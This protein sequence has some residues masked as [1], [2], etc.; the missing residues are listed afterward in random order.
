MHLLLLQ[1]A[2]VA[3]VRRVVG[4]GQVHLL[5]AAAVA[6]VRR[7]VRQGQVHLLHAA[8]SLAVAAGGCCWPVT[9]NSSGLLYGVLV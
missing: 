4:Q 1:A 9:P 5:Q 3:V 7:V 2:A 8:D 6:V